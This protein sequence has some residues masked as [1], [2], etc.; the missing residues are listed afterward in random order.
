MRYFQE[1]ESKRVGKVRLCGQI[2]LR[3]NRITK[4][5]EISLLSRDLP[6][7]HTMHYESKKGNIFLQG[8][9]LLFGHKFLLLCRVSD[10]HTLGNAALNQR[11][12]MI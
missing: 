7:Y 4:L 2:N 1:L 12:D 8:L 3:N 11:N 10:E 9:S 6:S 5:K